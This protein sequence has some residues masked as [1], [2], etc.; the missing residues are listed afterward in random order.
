MEKETISPAEI[1][2]NKNPEW[3]I[4]LKLFFTFCKKYNINYASASY[5]ERAFIAEVTR[6][7]YEIDKSKREGRPI[8][9][10]RLSFEE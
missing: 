5:K 1:Y 8:S 6:V 3:D 10:V 7:T 4:Y 9:E 2:I